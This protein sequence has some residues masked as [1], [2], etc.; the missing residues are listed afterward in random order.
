MRSRAWAHVANA[1]RVRSDLAGA[2]RAIAAAKEHLRKG[3]QDPIE[4]AGF[5]RSRAA[6]A[7]QIS[8]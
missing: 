2:D 3:M 8:R 4:I 5:I 6:T 1:R 7:R